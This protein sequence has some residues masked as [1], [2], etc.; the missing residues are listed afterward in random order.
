[1]SRITPKPGMTVEIS[2]QGIEKSRLDAIEAAESLRKANEAER[3]EA[4]FMRKEGET[5]RITAE[6]ERTM[7]EDA[8]NLAESGRI[9]AEE[10]RVTAENLRSNG[11]QRRAEAEKGRSIAESGRADAEQQRVESDEMRE[12]AEASRVT[13][14][15]ARANAEALRQQTFETNEANRHTAFESAE[16]ARESEWTE[17]KSNVESSVGLAVVDA[18]DAAKNANS[19][20][21]S[22]NA[23]AEKSVRYDEA[24]TLSDAQ[25]AQAREN[26]EA[27]SEAD[28]NELKGDVAAITPDDTAV[29]GKPWTSKKIVDALCPPLNTS[30]NPVQCHP[31][32]GYPLDVN[33]SWEPTQEGSGDP[34]PDN[35]RPIVG[36]DSVSVT[37]CG[38]NLVE[39]Q[40]APGYTVTKNGL[41]FTVNDDYSVTVKGTATAETY[42][43]FKP[44]KSADLIATDF[45]VAM[46]KTVVRNGFEIRDII[47]QPYPSQHN[48]RLY[49]VFAKDTVVDTTY[50]PT[51]VYGSTV[52]PYEPYTGDTYTAELPETIYGGELDWNTG[53]LTVDRRITIADGTVNKFTPDHM[54]TFWNMPFKSAPGT[55][56]V[57]GVQN[58][59]FKKDKFGLNGYNDFLFTMPEYMNGLFDTADNLNAYLVEQNASG[60]PV[61]FVYKLKT[62]YTVQLTPQQIAALSGVN[63]LYTDAGTL[64]VTGREDPRHTI[65]ELKNAILSLGGN[66]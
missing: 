46:G 16:N 58:S 57:M 10:S 17:I 36:L 54:G 1:M 6:Q 38:K 24:Q 30:G 47:V 29:D 32:A 49:L 5:G 31:V 48:T 65:V 50:Y 64:T 37:R 2:M 45:I 27:A 63:T 42:F 59:H 21:E 28:V 51:I 34:S 53:V 19:A 23:A 4:E 66:I 11:E 39:H 9:L 26:I 22:A 52:T 40:Y 12:N 25:K 43:N 60:T 56:D 3:A 18:E 20:A 15:T 14:E 8:R 62:P 13:A 7:E 44:I 33:V 35:I 41:T 55:I 61:I